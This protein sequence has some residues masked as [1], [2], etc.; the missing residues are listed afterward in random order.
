MAILHAAIS[1]SLFLRSYNIAIRRARQ[2]SGYAVT[3]L[4]ERR[5]RERERESP[6]LSLSLSL[7]LWGNESVCSLHDGARWT[8]WTAA[9]QPV[10]PP[11]PAPVRPSVLGLKRK[12]KRKGVI[13][14]YD[15]K[16]NANIP[17]HSAAAPLQFLL[18]NA[19]SRRCSFARSFV[20]F[21]HSALHRHYHHHT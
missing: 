11:A 14:F 9:H 21:S 17:P 18:R 10:R 4:D 3:R 19:H 12:E 16:V 5:E 13:T 1:P 20:S 7:S 8:D 6:P 15:I 2:I